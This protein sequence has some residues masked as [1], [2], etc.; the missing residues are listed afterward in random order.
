M[1]Q[2]TPTLRSTKDGALS[3]ELVVDGLLPADMARQLPFVSSLALNRTAIEAVQTVQEE[4]PRRFTRRTQTNQFFRQSFQVTQYSTKRDLQIAFGTSQAM[5]QGRSASLLDFEDG[6]DR[7]A[8]GRNKFPYIPAIG[9]SLRT[10][11]T[12][13]LPRWAY[14]K[15]LGLVDRRGIAGET[16]SGRD[17]TEARKGSKR[18]K[19]A[20]LNQKAFILRDKQ[21]DPIGIFRR[22]P[23]FGMRQSGKRDDGRAAGRRYSLARRRRRA[24]EQST[25][26]RLFWTP[27]VVRVEPRLG[28]R[29]LAH[30]EMLRRIDDNFVGMLAYALDARRQASNAAWLQADAA[31]VASFLRGRR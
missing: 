5:L 23:F 4:L 21:G 14:P 1:R 28:F 31:L 26:E 3:M 30:H 13:L 15:A 9:N 20:Q 19:R 6:T 11:V 10:S 27:K 7:V 22:I 29:R 25:L 8:S 18:G 24:T 2:I 17:R 16:I 12:D